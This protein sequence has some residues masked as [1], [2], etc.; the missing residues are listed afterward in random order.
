MLS[1]NPIMKKLL[2]LFI[3]LSP[4]SSAYSQELMLNHSGPIISTWIWQKSVGGT[5]NPYTATPASIGYNKK[6][7]FT[8]N[9]KVITYKNN[10][11]I[12]NSNY[13]IEKGISVFDHQEHDLL[14][15][16]GRTY[17]IENVDNQNLSLVTNN[18]DGARV[19]FKR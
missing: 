16:E 1:N 2:I 8:P 9:G 13:V 6:V 14:T 17:V 4:I 19:L 5:N 10:V 12:R 18:E 7:V 11:E 3:A 15:F